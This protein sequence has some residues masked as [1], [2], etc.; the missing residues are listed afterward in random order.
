MNKWTRL[1]KYAMPLLEEFF[2]GF[3]QAKGFNTLD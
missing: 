3:S 1:D 2:D